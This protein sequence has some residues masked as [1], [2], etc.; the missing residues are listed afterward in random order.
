LQSIIDVEYPLSLEGMCAWAA[1]D[2]DADV[3]VDVAVAV[4]VAGD[5]GAR[6]RDD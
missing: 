2:V 5:A 3:V 6:A 4:D 1:V